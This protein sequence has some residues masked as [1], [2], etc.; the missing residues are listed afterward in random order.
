M[1]PKVSFSYTVTK[2]DYF[3]ETLFE[4]EGAATPT[5]CCEGITN[6]TECGLAPGIGFSTN[7]N[8]EHGMDCQQCRWDFSSHT[9]KPFGCEDLTEKAP[10]MAAKCAGQCGHPQMDGQGQHCNGTF[11][12]GWDDAKRSCHKLDCGLDIT[13]RALGSATAA[14]DRCDHSVDPHFI[15]DGCRWDENSK[16]CSGDD[17]DRRQRSQRWRD[18]LSVLDAAASEDVW[19]STLGALHVADRPRGRRPLEAL[20]DGPSHRASLSFWLYKRFFWIIS[21]SLYS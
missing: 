2:H 10:C 11:V 18:E 12:C 13:V 7:G 1:S 20:R 14:K 21:F 17:D 16:S 6:A 5:P 3:F 8:N 15:G 4:K 9:C 19:Y